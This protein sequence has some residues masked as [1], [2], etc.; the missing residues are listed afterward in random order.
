[1]PNTQ[2]RAHRTQKTV[3]K[4]NGPNEDTSVPLGREKKA[5]R[6]GKEE[7]RRERRWGSR[8]EKHDWVLGGKHATSGGRRL[9]I[10][11]NVPETWEVRYSQDS[12]RGTLDEMPYIGER[13]L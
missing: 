8:E 2:D 5:T 9:G 6:R 13:N 11:Q 3:N 1:V 4:L 12:K 10:L 7:H